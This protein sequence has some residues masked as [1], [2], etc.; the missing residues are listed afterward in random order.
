MTKVFIDDVEYV[1][2]VGQPPVNPPPVYYYCLKCPQYF[3]TQTLLDAH[4]ASSHPVIIT[5]P[6]NSIPMVFG[7]ALVVDIGAGIT[8]VYSFSIT[9]AGKTSLK[10]N[11]YGMISTAN[12]AYKWF[13]PDGTEFPK[14]FVDKGIYVPDTIVGSS[15]SGSFE[16]R[17]KNN[18]SP[19]VDYP[20]IPMGIHLLQITAI[21]GS[22]IRIW[23][24]LR[25]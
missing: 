10:L 24:S 4:V 16:A 1:P 9:E 8:R 20:S 21:D 23:V 17:A 12:A 19:N 18:P 25:P 6:V 11:L 2:K 7:T 3:A 22:S 14:Y 5:P 13:F 15:S